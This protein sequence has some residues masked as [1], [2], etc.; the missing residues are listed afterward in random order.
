MKSKYE[1]HV[2]TLEREIERL[3]NVVA[4]KSQ[5]VKTLKKQAQGMIF[6]IRFSS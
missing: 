3:K 4:E 5:V 2:M 6:F 1:A